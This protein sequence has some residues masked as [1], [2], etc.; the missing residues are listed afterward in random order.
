MEEKRLRLLIPGACGLTFFLGFENGGFQL[1]LLNVASDFV[2]GPAMMGVLVASQYAAITLAPLIFGWI[3]DRIGKKPVLLLF[4]PLFAGGCFLAA[5]SGSVPAFLSGVFLTGIGYSVC[6]CIGSSALSDSFPGR[7]SR[8][9]NIMQCAFSVGAVVSPLIFSRL[10][11]S[12]GFTWRSVFVFSG[13]GYML[14]YPLILLAGCRKMVPPSGGRSFPALVRVLRSRFFLILLFSM[15][16]YVAMETGIGYFVDSLFV[17]EFDNTELGAYAISGFWFAMALSR[18]VFA[19]LKMKPRTMVLLGFSASAALLVMMLLF[20][21]QWLSLGVFMALGAMM[22]PVWPMILGIGTSSYQGISGTVASI[23]TAAGGLGGALAPVLIGAAGE[24]WG[25][26]GGFW[27]LAIIPL[28][29]FLVM[30]A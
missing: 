19:W 27:L 22:G 1:V 3:A 4:M 29:A 6:E 10:I 16:A 7:E 17:W 23:L 18:F 9:L 21:N 15:L 11:S 5:S 24:H 8:Y 13:C 25:L 26:Y 2:L 28:I 30:R 14:L 12:G 20:K